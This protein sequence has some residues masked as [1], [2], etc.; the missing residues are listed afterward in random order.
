MKVL[1]TG[2]AGFIGS[3]IVE[4][5]SKN[6]HSVIV[7]DN[8]SSGSLENI[9]GLE[10][11]KFYEIDIRDKRLIDIFLDEKPDLVYNEAAQ[12]SVTESIKDPYNDTSINLVGLVN[13]LDCCVK[14]NV[15]KFITASSAGVYGIPKNSISYETDELQA[16]S[17]YG[18]SK[19]TGEKYVKLYHDLYKL[20]YIILRYSN[21][22]GPRQ[23][24]KGE[25]GV[26]AIFSDAMVNNHDIYIDGD[27]LQTRDFIYV[28]DVASANY[29]VGIEKVENEIFNVSNNSNIS[30]ND[31]FSSMKKAFS[32]TKNAIHREKRVGDI[33]D[34]QLSNEKLLNMTSFRPEYS[35]EQGMSEYAGSIK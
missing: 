6:G 23:S 14:T 9:K 25:A 7:I 12:I 19:M 8:L 24:N 28:K 21:V 11:V 32:Y 20:P 35:L 3:H 31:L 27:G 1:V 26:V 10:N 33:R 13:V 4:K 29:A 34:S 5:F 16:L 30:I 22:F 2:G 18:L 15:K 17:F